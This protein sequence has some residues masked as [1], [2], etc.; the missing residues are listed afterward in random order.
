MCPI[1]NTRNITYKKKKKTIMNCGSKAM[2]FILLKIYLPRVEKNLTSLK[3][4][5]NPAMGKRDVLQTQS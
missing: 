1:L 2:I 4:K 3:L 5:A